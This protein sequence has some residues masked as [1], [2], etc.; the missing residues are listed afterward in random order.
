MVKLQNHNVFLSTIN[1]W[2]LG[3]IETNLVLKTLFSQRA[4]LSGFYTL[5]FVNSVIFFGSGIITKLAQA[6]Q[7]INTSLIFAEFRM[8]FA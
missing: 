8:L 6:L 5:F 7:S 2:M 3:Q 4:S 1:T